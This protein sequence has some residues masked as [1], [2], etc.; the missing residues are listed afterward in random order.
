MSSSTIRKALGAVKDQTSIGLAKVTSNIAPELDVLI[1]KATSHDD[2]PAEERHIREILHLTSGSRAHVAAAVAGCSRRLSRTRDYVVALKSLMLVHRLLADGDPS[3]HRELLHATRR[4][5]RLL[6]LSDFRD[7]AHSGS[8]D[9]SA[10]VR[11]YALYLDQRLEFFLHERKQGS[12]SNASSSAKW[13][14]TA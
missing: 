9:H 7:E 3:F 14:V 4:G 11:T 5:T 8:W 2:E 1:V 13:P 6:N 10:F 12:G